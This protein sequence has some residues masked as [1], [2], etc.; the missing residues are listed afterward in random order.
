MGKFDSL[1]AMLDPAAENLPGAAGIGASLT[2][3]QAIGDGPR[4]LQV[5]LSGETSPAF[6]KIVSNGAAGFGGTVATS[7][8]FDFTNIKH[9]SMVLTPFDD[10]VTLDA[11]PLA[12]R[13]TLSL[14]GG[15]GQDFLTVDF[16]GLKNVVF[17]ADSAG[18]V[19]SNYGS[20]AGFEEYTIRLG[21]GVNSVTTG[22][23]GD[24][25]SSRSGSFNTISTGDGM[26]QIDFMGIDHVDGGD[27]YDFWFGN[28][29]S[30]SAGLTFSMHGT[31]GTLSN[32]TTLTNVESFILTTGSGNDT[33]DIV[34]VKS[35]AGAIVDGGR[36]W[37]VL[38]VDFSD[39]TDFG[40]T[41]NIRSNGERGFSGDFFGS[42]AVVSFS[43]ME[44]VTL[45]AGIGDD[46][47]SVDASKQSR[48]DFAH[49]W[50]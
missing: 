10:S 25:V 14:D 39:M 32:G 49:R 48:R 24:Q 42:D 26:D 35:V 20:F 33:F 4:G 7:T 6:V 28:Y 2:I 41:S 22:F 16:T 8:S 30:S 21:G 18:N 1:R 29:A 47:I 40:G 3:A 15:A 17:E 11:S 36:G 13:A 37:D 34:D 44:A 46:I 9:L 5:D 38:R 12:A 43:N 19:H 45:L 31:S 27:G 23:A 50:W